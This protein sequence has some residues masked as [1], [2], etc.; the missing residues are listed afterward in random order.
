MQMRWKTIIDRLAVVF[1]IAAKNQ[2]IYLRFDDAMLTSSWLCFFFVDTLYKRFHCLC[3]KIQHNVMYEV[4]Y[5]GRTSCVSNC[6]IRTEGL[7][8][9]VECECQQWLSCCSVSSHC[10]TTSVYCVRSVKIWDG[11]STEWEN[12]SHKATRAVH[13]QQRRHRFT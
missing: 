7:L 1:Y 5:N 11:A 6:H 10:N 2:S 4:S 9:D 12:V 13:A 3:L 8:R